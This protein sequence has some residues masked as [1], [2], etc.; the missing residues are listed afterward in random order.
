MRWLCAPPSDWPRSA[1]WIGAARA[2][3]SPVDPPA[4]TVAVVSWVTDGDTIGGRTQDGTTSVR[5]R[6]RG[7]NAPE[8]AHD[9]R[10]QQSWAGQARDR[11]AQLAPVGSSVVAAW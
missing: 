7:L 3:H 6:L 9:N 2:H 11:L 8:L 1:D 5:I 10:P 4:A